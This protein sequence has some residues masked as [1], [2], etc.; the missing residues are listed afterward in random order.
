MSHR[1]AFCLT[2]NAMPLSLNATKKRRTVFKISVHSTHSTQKKSLENDKANRGVFLKL[3]SRI[4]CWPLNPQRPRNG[5]GIF[6][7]DPPFPRNEHGKTSH[8]RNAWQL[9]RKGNRTNFFYIFRNL[10]LHFRLRFTN[11]VLH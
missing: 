1:R 2:K 5:D 9:D 8:S 7:D 6:F 11:N 4:F 3:S 10:R